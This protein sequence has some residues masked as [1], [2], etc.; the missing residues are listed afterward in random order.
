MWSQDLYSKAWTF[1]CHAHHGQTMLCGTLPYINHI[2]N[3]A[4]EVTAALARHSDIAANQQNL[5]IQTALLHDTLEDTSI[6][7]EDLEELFGQQ[8]AQAVD[9]LSK[10]PSLPT[11]KARMKDSLL[12]IQEQPRVVWMVKLADRIVN[13]SRVP[14]RWSEEKRE[15]YQREAEL[16]LAELGPACCYLQ[17]RL[18]KRIEHY[19][20]KSQSILPHDTQAQLIQTSSISPN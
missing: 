11:S 15:D 5:A 10:N 6:E 4:M 14:T 13:L 16:I 12:R 2:V 19:P 9:A 1:A 18:S 7:F 20:P 17:H 8:V 3:V